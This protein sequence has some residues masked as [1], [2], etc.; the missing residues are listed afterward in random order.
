MLNHQV[1]QAWPSLGLCCAPLWH[2]LPRVA[3]GARAPGWQLC[4]H[5]MQGSAVL[6]WMEALAAS[7]WGEQWE[8]RA[9]AMVR[10]LTNVFCAVDWFN[11]HVRALNVLCQWLY[12][13]CVLWQLFNVWEV[14]LTHYWGSVKE[15]QTHIVCVL[16]RGVTGK[17]CWKQKG[18]QISDIWDQTMGGIVFKHQASCQ[19]LS[20]LLLFFLSLWKKSQSLR[21]NKSETHIWYC[22]I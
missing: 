11:S 18:A 8:F 20:V 2:L 16:G 5:W 6:H 1:L 21:T 15:E 9:L 13:S 4:Q 10:V 17:K 19:W 12:K 7:W 22:W 14:P 3:D